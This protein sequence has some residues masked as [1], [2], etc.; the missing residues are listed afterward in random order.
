MTRPMSAR[1][2]S[3]AR[4]SETQQLNQRIGMAIRRL[5]LLRGMDQRELATALGMAPQ[6]LSKIERGSQRLYADRIPTLIRSLSTTATELLGGN[7]VRAPRD[8][9]ARLSL[10]HRYLPELGPED[11]LTLGRIA[12][13]MALVARRRKDK[14]A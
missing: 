13:A 10:V 9:T 1:K 3:S 14:A 7:K 2:G 12:R 6:G 11:M 5:R 8:N 4:E